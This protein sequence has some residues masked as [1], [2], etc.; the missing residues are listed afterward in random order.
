MAYRKE[1]EQV[2]KELTLAKMGL[3]AVMQLQG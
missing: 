3:A 1:I 2:F